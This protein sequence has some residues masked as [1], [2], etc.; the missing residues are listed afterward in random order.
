MVISHLQ[1]EA[2]E[3]EELQRARASSSYLVRTPLRL[4][5]G[6][7]NEFCCWHLRLLSRKYTPEHFKELCRAADAAYRNSIIVSPI[8]TPAF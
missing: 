6:R 4:V 3:A 1:A 7:M 8:Y 2:A 5:S